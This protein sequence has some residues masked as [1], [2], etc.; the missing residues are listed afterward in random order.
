MK[1][2]IFL[3]MLAMLGCHGLMAKKQQKPIIVAYVASWGSQ[4]MPDPTLMTHLNYAFGK[5]TNTFDGMTGVSSTH[6]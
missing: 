6:F 4:R 1:R 3:F 5:V 2:I